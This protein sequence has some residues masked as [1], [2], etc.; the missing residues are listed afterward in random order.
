MLEYFIIRGDDT[1]SI[2]VYH[3]LVGFMV[4]IYSKHFVL[5]WNMGLLLLVGSLLKVVCKSC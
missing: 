2:Q 5:L 4:A 3:E 1:S